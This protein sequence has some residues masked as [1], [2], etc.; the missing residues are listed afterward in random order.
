MTLFCHSVSAAKRV[1]SRGAIW[2]RRGTT[3]DTQQIS[4]CRRTAGRGTSR[5]CVACRSAGGRNSG[6]CGRCACDPG[7]GHRR[8]GQA[9]RR[10]Q[11]DGA[12]QRRA[13][14]R[15]D[16]RRHDPC[17]AGAHPGSRGAAMRRGGRGR[18]R[19]PP[20]SAGARGA[21]FARRGGRRGGCLRGDRGGDQPL[22][23]FRCGLEP[24]EAGR[25][26]QQRCLRACRAVR[27]IG[28][29]WNSAS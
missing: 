5:R 21:L 29:D 4:R 28:A 16:L 10:I 7:C 17:L 3:M 6:E 27:R 24:G 19:V 2:L 14:A 11:G 8:A 25:L 26:H 15:R 22:S 1:P 9:G 12:G 20:R 13:D 23:Q 18:V